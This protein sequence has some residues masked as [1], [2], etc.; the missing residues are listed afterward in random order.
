[1]RRLKRPGVV[2][3][4]IWNCAGDFSNLDL[5]FVDFGTR[6]F[7]DQCPIQVL[8]SCQDRRS[9]RAGPNRYL[10]WSKQMKFGETVADPGWGNHPTDLC[11]GEGT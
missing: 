8:E 11:T 6:S 7:F 9:Q 1:M 2:L 4:Y 3:S 10:V 5:G